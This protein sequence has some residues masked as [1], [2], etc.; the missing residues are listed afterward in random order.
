MNPI[1]AVHPDVV[2]TVKSLGIVKSIFPLLFLLGK[3]YTV[4]KS[5]LK[6]HVAPTVSQLLLLKDVLVNGLGVMVTEFDIDPIP[7]S[8]EDV[9]VV[10]EKLPPTFCV[11]SLIFMLTV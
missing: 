1:V 2:F 10:T 4:V 5:T 7:M 8:A 3:V 11:F 6:V 9:F